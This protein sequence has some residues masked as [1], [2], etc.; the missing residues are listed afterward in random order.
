M[1][2]RRA[3]RRQSFEAKSIIWRRIDYIIHKKQRTKQNAVTIMKN[4]TKFKNNNSR[5]G[6]S[7]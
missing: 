4:D 6:V 7:S 2:Y 5:Q 1:K 3:E